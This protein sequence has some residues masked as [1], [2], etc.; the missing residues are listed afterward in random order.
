MEGEI[1]KIRLRKN[2]SSHKLLRHLALGS[3]MLLISLVAPQAAAKVVQ[4]VISSYFRRKSFER[5]RFLNDLK[6]LQTK[7][8]IDF[9][10]LKDGSVRIVLASK[11]KQAGERIVLQDKLDAMK[12]NTSHRWDRKWRLVI[13]DIPHKHK[14]GRDA[15]ARKLRDLGMYPLQKSVY[16]TPYPCENEINFITSIFEVQKYVLILHL[17]SFEGQEKFEHHF[18]LG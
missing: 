3:G 6:N 12:L 4:N 16:I 9:R 13:F 7:E 15:L 2:S 1:G 18:R 8:L 17:S 14:K 5:Q 10:E 11:G